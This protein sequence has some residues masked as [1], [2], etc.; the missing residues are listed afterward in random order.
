MA[1]TPA[2]AEKSLKRYLTKGQWEIRGKASLVVGS[3]LAK[4]N[5]SSFA[6]TRWS[7]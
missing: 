6:A 5:S 4:K 7:W 1:F 2:D 3:E